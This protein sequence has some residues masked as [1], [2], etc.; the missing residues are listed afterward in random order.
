MFFLKIFAFVVFC[1]HA[2]HFLFQGKH[3]VYRYNWTKEIILERMVSMTCFPRIFVSGGLQ[4]K[5]ESLKYSCFI[6]F[7][8]NH[9][10][11]LKLNDRQLGFL[12]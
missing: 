9:L 11:G 8:E 2:F 7:G 1:S 10:E 3:R 5:Q 12:N 4:N 6:V